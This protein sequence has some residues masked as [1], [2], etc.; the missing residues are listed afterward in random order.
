MLKSD[1]SKCIPAATGE[2][3]QR[4]KSTISRHIKNV[5]AQEELFGEAVVANF[6][7]TAT[8][9][10]TYPVDHYY[11]SAKR[12]ARVIRASRLSSVRFLASSLS[13]QNNC[14]SLMFVSKNSLGVTPR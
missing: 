5:S 12:S 13:L 14:G 7:T 10:K 9:G 1:K 6:A 8:D 3:F 11:L 4:V 2:V